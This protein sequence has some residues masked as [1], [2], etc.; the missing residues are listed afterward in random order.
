MAYDI[1]LAQFNKIATGDYNA[2]QIDIKVG[3]NGAAELVKVNNHVWKTSKNGVQLSPQRVLEVKEAFLSALAKGGVKDEDLQEIRDRLGLPSKL[4]AFYAKEK[5][6]DLLKIRFAPLTRAQVRSLLDEYADGGRGFT[7]E[8]IA[9]VSQRDLAAAR[10]T[11]N[12]SAGRAGDRDKVNMAAMA[13]YEQSGNAGVDFSITDAISLLSTG[14]QLADL[15]TARRNRIGGDNAV[16][17]RN[18]S[19]TVLKNGFET[20]FLQAIKMLPAGVRESASFN[21]CGIETKLVKGDDGK[22]GAVLGSGEL[23]TAVALGKD[24][25]ELLCGFIGLSLAG[26]DVLGPAMLKGLLGKVYDHDIELGLTVDDRTSYSRHFAVQILDRNTTEAVNILNGNYNTG[27]LVEMAERVIDNMQGLNTKQQLDAYHEK[28][29][30]DTSGLPDDI[31][32]ILAQ[33]ANIEIEKPDN[34]E[35][36][37]RAP[38]TGSIDDVVKKLP[39]Q[40][41]PM[42]TLPRDIGGLE[43]IKNFVADIVFSD[44]TMVADVVVKR[45]GETMRTLLS[46]DRRIIALAEIVKN[47]GVLDLAVSGEILEAVKEGFG[48]LIA[49]LDSEYQRV[50]GEKL[51]DAAKKDDFL[52]KFS[53]FVKDPG[54]LAAAELAKFDNIIQAMANKGCEK[55]QAFINNDVFKVNLAGADASGAITTNP[56]KDMD[57]N[58]IKALLSDKRNTLNAILD[59]AATSNVPG[60]VGFFRQVISTYFTKLGKA[61]KRAAFA[62][63]MRYAGTFDFSGIVGDK[64]LVSAQKAAVNKFTGAI[65]KGTSPLLQKMLQGLPREIVG[66]YADALA[67]MKTNLAPIP[68]KL[69]Q[70]HLM[71]LVRNSN[72]KIKAIEV[73]KSL[74]A[75]SVGEAFLCKVHVVK[76]KKPKLVPKL[77]EKG[78]PVFDMEK[79]AKVYEEV[80]DNQGNVVME[81]DISEKMVVVKIMRH[82]AEKRV[83]SEAEIFNAAAE[84]VPGMAKTWQGQYE[85]Y[86]KEFDFHNEAANVN[87]GYGLYGIKG[88]EEH[89]L[90]AVAPN[91]TSMRM[92]DLFP[93][94]KD[95][96]VVELEDG[97]TIDSYFKLEVAEIRTA[98]SSVFK[99]DPATNRIMWE[100]GPLDPETGKPTKKPVFRD[101]IGATSVFSLQTWFMNNYGNLSRVSKFLLQATKAWFYEA[102]IGSGTFHG[103]THAGNL[104]VSANQISF[105]DFGNLYK[106]EPA[107]QKNLL[108]VI[109]G[110]AFRDKDMFLNGMSPLL[111]AEGRAALEKNA[112]KAKAILDAVL[113]KSKGGFSFN[114]VYRLQAAV[115][116]LQKLGLELPPQIN[117][118]IQ[119]MVRLSNTVAEINT[120]MNQCKAMLDAVNSYVHVAPERD[121]LDLLGQAFDIY[122]TADGKKEVPSGKKKTVPAFIK[123]LESDRFGGR[124]KMRAPMFTA[125]GS[126]TV[127]VRDRLLDSAQPM[128]EARKLVDVLRK[129]GDKE[130]N[131]LS[132]GAVERI[133]GDLLKFEGAYAAANTDEEKAEA[134]KTFAFDYS[135]AERDLLA[136]MHSCIEMTR[137]V[138]L[139]APDAF[140]S[141]ITNIL[142]DN[143]FTL[144]E[145]MTAK[146]GASLMSSASSIARNELKL[147]A[148]LSV[149]PSRVVDTIKEDAKSMGTDKDY[150]VNIGV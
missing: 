57:A 7:Q 8:S 56:Y 16:N 124:D 87:A 31:K 127:K 30:R 128:E 70:A 2:G 17:E 132:A 103:D 29:S 143:F 95:V 125:E 58:G 144:Q 32:N 42:P 84:K 68:R 46:D 3:E 40:V 111:S 109:L 10:R 136:N 69:V 52:G 37:V 129:H 13:R 43:G 139:D 113:D 38:M 5:R 106:L 15:N 88:N 59:S 51:A 22:L 34:G 55:I 116:E 14:R 92:S 54:K 145:S 28:L 20:V 134:I 11:A 114:I 100:D 6:D 78:E 83:E 101:D 73:E 91:V 99:R 18:D 141:A 120:I 41:G 67:D 94:H 82:D 130:H 35:L 123:E 98:A 135:L 62:A 140:A 121:E 61:D 23:A 81:D 72:G 21:L 71:N 60:Q 118:F 85:Q 50:H 96:M 74:G 65:L 44:D 80:R 148:I 36:I 137:G 86:K 110:A 107:E 49:I 77:N 39:K 53:L 138:K 19:T 90:H 75:A 150:Q 47:S 33:V 147:N 25:D 146:E 133:E 115:I 79:H 102:L 64:E 9:A 76:G 97:E 108:R 93:V 48:K 89:G 142:F 149:I 12:M 26:R 4:D 117:C 112:D 105:I 45:P 126:Y 66:D 1:S 63:S 122:A 27:L 104:M 24:A 119:S 131:L